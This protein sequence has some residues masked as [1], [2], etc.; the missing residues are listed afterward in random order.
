MVRSKRKRRILGLIGIGIA[1]GTYFAGD[2]LRDHFKERRDELAS[3]EE[4]FKTQT[5]QT[6]ISRQI[7]TLQQ[8]SQL[9]EIQKQLSEPEKNR[10]YSLEIQEGTGILMAQLSNMK[11]DLDA[12]SRLISHLSENT[13]LQSGLKIL[14]RETD[15]AQSEVTIAIQPSDAHDLSRAVSVEIEIL[16]VVTTNIYMF[17]EGNSAIEEA[18]REGA[19]ANDMYRYSTS[20]T[21]M[22]CGLGFILAAY[23]V[24]TGV[25]LGLRAE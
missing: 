17:F 10:D 19:S 3:A 20:A 24:L 11:V 1:V 22:F 9:P 18:E 13:K 14:Q 2:V 25:D 12:T 16:K 23:G 7:A 5:G 4:S 21:W 15:K 6:N 8:Y